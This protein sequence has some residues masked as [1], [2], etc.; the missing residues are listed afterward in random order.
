MRQSSR[1]SLNGCSRQLVRFPLECTMPKKKKRLKPFNLVHEML[2][3]GMV[4]QKASC[5]TYVVSSS[6]IA[7]TEYLLLHQCAATT[8]G[9]FSNQWYW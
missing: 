9:Q 8:A 6:W 1:S 4:R 3:Q 2:L 7:P 5:A